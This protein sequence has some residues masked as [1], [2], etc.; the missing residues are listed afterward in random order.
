MK[1]RIYQDILRLQGSKHPVYDYKALENA[2]QYIESVLR[3]HD[4]P[5]QSEPF[6]VEGVEKPFR[7][8]DASIGDQSLPTLYIGSHYDTVFTSPGANDNAS[9]TAAMLELVRMF[10]GRKDVHIR[11][12]FFTLEELNPVYEQIK[13]ET[14]VKTGIW[15][16]QRT[17]QSLRF[18]EDEQRFGKAMH[19]ARKEVPSYGGQFKLA[20]EQVTDEMSPEMCHLYEVLADFCASF[21]DPMG[22]GQRALLGSCRWVEENRPEDRSYIGMVDLDSIGYSNPKPFS[23]VMPDGITPTAENSFLVDP[24]TQAGDYIVAVTNGGGA[25]MMAGFT[26]A[27]RGAK[28]PYFHMACPLSYAE[29]AAFMPELLLAD[30]GAF[31]KRGLPCLFLTDTGATFRYPFEHTPADTIDKLDFDFMEKIVVC[32]SESIPKWFEEVRK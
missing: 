29:T 16:E 10:A 30:H 18:R 13:H 1:E 12:L 27:A 14:A 6:F 19:D 11:L 5:F 28:L 23:H 20:L 24:A 32:L 15:D 26:Q 2:R 25:N 22:F 8:I 17:Y 3:D 31:W 4:V 9:G 21:D 7:N